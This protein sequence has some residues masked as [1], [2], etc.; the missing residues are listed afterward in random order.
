MLKLLKVTFDKTP[1]RIG[2]LRGGDMSQI[3]ADKSSPMD[4][5][6]VSIRGNV[7]FLISPKGWVHG[8]PAN[9]WDPEGTAQTHEFPRTHCFFHWEG[10]DTELAEFAK[11]GKF[12]SPPFG[13]PPPPVTVEPPGILGNLDPAQMGDE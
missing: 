8:Q 3:S 1:A 5:W 12:D 11:H 9:R 4:G 13:P 2:S 10:S 7:V 6:R